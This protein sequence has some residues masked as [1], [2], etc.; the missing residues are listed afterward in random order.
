MESTEETK[1]FESELYLDVY[2]TNDLQN[3]Y[4]QISVSS[5]NN[6]DEVEDQN[7]VIKIIETKFDSNLIIIDSQ[8]LL[9]DINKLNIQ[10]VNLLKYCKEDNN[11]KKIN[12]IFTVFCDYFNLP[13]NSCYSS[14]HEKIQ[15]LI[16]NS[17]IKLVG[18]EE[19]NK[20]ENRLNPISNRTK[21]LFDLVKNKEH[22][23]GKFCRIRK[24]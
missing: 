21:T 4:R 20:I 5:S 6:F 15:Q 10:F 16:R 1:P 9:R 18:E 12:V 2:T 19:Y 7:Y 14:F 17:F 3:L 13:Y 24:I 8:I 11:F 22:K 23:Y